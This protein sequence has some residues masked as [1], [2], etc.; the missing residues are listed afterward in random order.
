VAVALVALLGVAGGAMVVAAIPGERAPISPRPSEALVATPTPRPTPRS[1]TTLEPTPE[2]SPV[3]TGRGPLATAVPAGD[4]ADLCEIFFDV[5]CGLGPGRYAPSRFQPAFDI[6]LGDGWSTAAHREDIVALTRAEGS[7]TFAGPI[8]EVYPHGESSEPR[9]R[10]RDLIEAFLATD[11]VGATVPAGVRIG[12]RRG[13]STDL[14]PTEHHRITLFSTAGS[15]YNLE[16][17]RVTRIVV[18]DLL[19]GDTVLIAIESSDGHDLR[20]ILDTADPA[21]GT[22]HW[23]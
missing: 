18:I 14:A 19:G 7:L 1:T 9:A 10:A 22:I 3:A 21:A 16:P 8:R 13:L 12:G 4:V 11:G 15:T 20:D 2:P 5:P 17:D 6:E 23:R